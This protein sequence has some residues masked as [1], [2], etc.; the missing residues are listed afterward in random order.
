MTKVYGFA[1]G[2]VIFAITA[3]VSQQKTVERNV[4]GLSDIIKANNASYD[5]N[6]SDQ[7]KARRLTSE[8]IRALASNKEKLNLQDGRLILDNDVSFES[9]LNMIK[10]AKKEIRMVYFIYSDD[11]SSS[12]ISQAL[13]DKAKAGVDVTLLVDFITNYGK[14]DHFKMMAVE[15]GSKLKVHFYNFPSK[16]VLEDAKYMTLPCP[17]DVPNP[18]ASQCRDF[19]A[20]PMKAL[21]SSETTPFS[22]MFLAGLYGKNGTALK[23]TMGYGA[24]IDPAKLKAMKNET[25]DQESAIIF[26]FFK[27]AREAVSGDPANQLLAKIKVSSALASEGATLNPVLTE[28]TGRLPFLNADAKATGISHADEW[29]HLT[30]YVHHKLLAVDG[31]EFQLGGRNIE[32]SY[33]MKSRLGSKGKYIFMDTDFYG[34]TAAGGT[35]EIEASFDKLIR[36]SPADL[37]TVQRVIPNDLISNPEQ[38]M[39]A[40]GYC[41]Q[42][43][44]AGKVPMNALGQCIE[45]AAPTIEGFKNQATRIATSKSE[46][47][48][49]RGRYNTDYLA[50]K[51]NAP[52]DHFRSGPYT[53]GVDQLSSSDLANAEIYYLE[54]VAYAKNG[55]LKRRAGA[56]VGAE[57]KF[58]KNI[59]AAWY[60]GLESACSVSREEK[61]EVRVV[62]HTAYLFMP[63]GMMHRLAKMMNGDYQD[64][65]RVRIT[66]L[67]NSIETT[68]LNVIN[69]FARY[70]M[71]ELIKHHQG[72]TAAA[73]ALDQ[74]NPYRKAARFFPKLDFF[75]YNASSVGTGISLHTKISILGDDMIVGSA[76]ADV[77]SY[78]MDTNNAVLIRGAKDFN[79]DYLNYVDSI[80]TDSKKSKNLVGK[81]LDMKPEDIQAENKVL[82]KYMLARWDKKGKINSEKQTQILGHIDN[83]G[84]KISNTTQR[85]LNFRGDFEQ[86]KYQENSQSGL[87]SLEREL[88]SL[89]NSFDDLFKVL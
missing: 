63:S 71:N 37:T 61:R 72:L 14:L 68:D 11:D 17:P 53:D 12:L 43:A 39:K 80:L 87:S 29:D 32:D 89:A 69:I 50:A 9:K 42:Q 47:D 6:F 1:I 52:R 56:R 33:H 48:Q 4:A 86:L 30:D 58:N 62:M 10:R 65:S 49:S 26:D 51:K 13:I 67:T 28:M 8:Q 55:D 77:R 59:H 23:V 18:T 79:R 41:L 64:C 7:S 22:K 75:E 60:R 16:R 70:Q 76:N 38:L 78:Y 5:T 74:G 19:K 44:Q 31:T 57:A 24:G 2:A 84:A 81:Y 88:N 83:I 73:D 66:F 46:M 54:N 34:R 20:A 36:M 25:D 35:K 85:L 45:G 40:T 15:G 21:E 27:V 82:L 3:C